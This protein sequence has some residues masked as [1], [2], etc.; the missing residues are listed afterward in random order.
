MKGGVCATQC[1]IGR[2]QNSTKLPGPPRRRAHAT[3][4]DVRVKTPFNLPA[5]YA[6]MP[7]S[8]PPKTYVWT[9]EEMS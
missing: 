6:A 5:V 1:G 3:D 7:P 2:P 4:F 9:F 8:L